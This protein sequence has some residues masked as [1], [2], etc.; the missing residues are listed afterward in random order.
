V[1]PQTEQLT[2]PEACSLSKAVPDWN[3]LSNWWSL[4]HFRVNWIIE[5]PAG[6]LF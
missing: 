2:M 6:V 1:V 3:Q 4:A 5:M